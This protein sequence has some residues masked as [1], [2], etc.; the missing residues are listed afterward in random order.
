M[1]PD[2]HFE[3]ILE[4]LHFVTPYPSTTRKMSSSQINFDMYSIASLTHRKRFINDE[5]RTLF[6]ISFPVACQRL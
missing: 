6:S 5:L 3:S 1:L 2:W 4:L